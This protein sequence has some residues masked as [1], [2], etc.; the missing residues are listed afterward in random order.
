MRRR[1]YTLLWLLFLVKTMNGQVNTDKFVEDFVL[2]MQAGRDLTHFI[3]V[4][5]SIS[6]KP[7]L[8]NFV[9]IEHFHFEKTDP[10]NYTVHIDPGIG[11]KCLTIDLR[12]VYD[13]SEQ[14]K[15]ECGGVR[16]NQVINKYFINPWIA[17][18]SSC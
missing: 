11:K 16:F 10:L 12:I 5:D 18:N 15:F 3:V 17:R 8:V 6:G 9:S 7:Y 1:G 2:S 14:L 13:D 4:P